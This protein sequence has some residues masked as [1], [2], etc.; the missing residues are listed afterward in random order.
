VRS[1]TS[2][3][4]T[5][6]GAGRPIADGGKFI[7]QNTQNRDGR[8]IKT[9]LDAQ[10]QTLRSIA[11][12]FGIDTESLRALLRTV[13]L[14]DAPESDIKRRQDEIREANGADHDGAATVPAANTRPAPAY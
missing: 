8:G 13:G 4:T 12:H 1:S 3:P 7:I 11:D 10:S 9:E 5:W 6:L 2:Y 14:E